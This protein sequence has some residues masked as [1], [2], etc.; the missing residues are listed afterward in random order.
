M[1]AAR[2]AMSFPLAFFNSQAVALRLMAKN[3]MN[4]YWYGSIAN[5]FDNFE[6]YEDQDGNTY[7]KAS[8]APA[9]TNLTVRYPIPY[10]DKLPKVIKDSL[11]PFTDARGGGLKWN[12]K[13]M[14]FMLA[15]PSV[16]WFG[17]VTLSELVKNGFSAP[18]G[19]WKVYGEDISEALRNNLGDD[20][21]QN[22]LLFGGYPIEGKN[23]AETAKNAIV[24]SYLQSLIDSGKI[25]GP[26][27][28]VMGAVGLDKSERFADDVNM[29]FRV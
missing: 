24:P 19:L 13:Q 21:Y 29:F 28:A 16:S 17:G 18:G 27:A 23:V 14:E 5:A 6:S 1:Y 26:I 20:F 25:P 2:F 8:D 4:A 12:P 11:K 22:S 9:G 15:D 3:P 7:K 10:G